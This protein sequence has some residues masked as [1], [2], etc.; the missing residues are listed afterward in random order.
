MGTNLSSPVLSRKNILN[1][2]LVVIGI[3]RPIKTRNGYITYDQSKVTSNISTWPGVWP[4][5]IKW[6]LC[7]LHFL[8][9]REELVYIVVVIVI[10]CD[11]R[12]FVTVIMEANEGKQFPC[13]P[14]AS[15]DGVVGVINI[16]YCTTN[17]ILLHIQNQHC[18][19]SCIF[20]S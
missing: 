9:Q 8:H 3:R 20:M 15:E 12:N 7:I 2:P 13:L 1:R 4:Q 17:V 14:L 6:S 5:G 16:W 18:E 19:L 11:R 10:S